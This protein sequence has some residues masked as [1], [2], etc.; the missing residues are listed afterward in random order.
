MCSQTFIQVFLSNITVPSEV[1]KSER[2]HKVKV[3]LQGHIYFSGF[4]FSLKKN[5]FFYNFD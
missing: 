4:N 5:N 2:V 1:K 3:W